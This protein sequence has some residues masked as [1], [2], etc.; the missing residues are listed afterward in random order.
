MGGW[1]EVVK[2]PAMA[3]QRYLV[4]TRR[5]AGRDWR[6]VAEK[7]LGLCAALLDRMDLMQVVR[8]IRAVFL[9]RDSRRSGLRRP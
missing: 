6:V 7:R 3:G 1:E 4:Q 9:A 2:L 8:R 5:R